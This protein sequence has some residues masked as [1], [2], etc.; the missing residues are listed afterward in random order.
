MVLEYGIH[1]QPRALK[2]TKAVSA[3]IHFDAIFL[4]SDIDYFVMKIMKLNNL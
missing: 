2:L 3:G 1:F 4:R